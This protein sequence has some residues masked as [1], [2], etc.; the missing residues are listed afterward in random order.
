MIRDVLPS[1]RNCEGAMVATIPSCHRMD[2]KMLQ[3]SGVGLHLGEGGRIRVFYKPTMICLSLLYSLQGN[4]L[5][6]FP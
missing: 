4:E 6:Y 3:I 5:N 2:A 1:L